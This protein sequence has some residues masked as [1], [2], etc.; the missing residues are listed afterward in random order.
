M[1]FEYKKNCLTCEFGSNN[2]SFDEDWN[3]DNPYK[4][5][6]VWNKH[7]VFSRASEI[8][9]KKIENSFKRN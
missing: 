2:V 5:N 9:L 4:L 8:F 3:T 1:S 7:Q 6:I